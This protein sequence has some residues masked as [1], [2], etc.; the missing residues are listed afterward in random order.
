MLRKPANVFNEESGEP[1]WACGNDMRRSDAEPQSDAQT[2]QDL[3]LLSVSLYG[4]GKAA[5][6]EMGGREGKGGRGE[7]EGGGRGVL[8]K[9]LNTGSGHHRLQI[10]GLPNGRHIVA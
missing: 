8:S 5:G 10:W 6:R 7:E 1:N 4:R 3:H 9:I 2:T